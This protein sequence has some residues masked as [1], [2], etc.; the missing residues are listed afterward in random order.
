MHKSH[1]Q[2]T[3]RSPAEREESTAQDVPLES[4]IK[5]FLL[6]T[7]FIPVAIKTI[8][9]P[10]S[11]LSVEKRWEGEGHGKSFDLRKKG[12]V[13][14]REKKQRRK[15][16][17]LRVKNVLVCQHG[18]DV[19]G[20]TDG[21]SSRETNYIAVVNLFSLCVCGLGAVPRGCKYTHV[22]K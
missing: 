16:G 14:R 20:D 13:E 21:N 5:F 12:Q 18:L 19:S 11:L 4:D 8:L 17:G 10:P 2:A 7:K 15:E 6:I 9:P 22:V 3:C 1:Q